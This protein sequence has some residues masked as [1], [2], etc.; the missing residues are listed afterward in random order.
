MRQQRKNKPAPPIVR[1]SYIMSF[2]V[3]KPFL[4]TEKVGDIIDLA[5]E[6]TFNMRDHCISHPKHYQINE[7]MERG[8]VVKL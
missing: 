3:V 5:L 1:E 7:F 2:K 4:D 8:V 6:H